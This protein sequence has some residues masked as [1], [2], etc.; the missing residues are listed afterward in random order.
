MRH[1]DV[2]NSTPRPH[3]LAIFYSPASNLP[4]LDRWKE[5]YTL[6]GTILFWYTRVSLSNR[7]GHSQSPRVQGACFH[8]NVHLSIL[9]TAVICDGD[10]RLINGENL[11]ER[12][13]ATNSSH[14]L[15]SAS[16]PNPS[17]IVGHRSRKLWGEPFASRRPKARRSIHLLSNINITPLQLIR[18]GGGASLPI[19][20]SHA[21]SLVPSSSPVL[22]RAAPAHKMLHYSVG[23]STRAACESPSTY[24]PG[25]SSH[26][27]SRRK[28]L[29]YVRTPLVPLQRPRLLVVVVNMQTHPHRLRG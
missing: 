26:H 12:V 11:L 28:A 3:S 6:V 23:E 2:L 27:R 10:P 25:R 8:P 19:P 1:R 4:F 14:L 18:G 15:L 5:G 16:S 29:G 17:S 20:Y 9:L 24:R 7:I 21:H 13:A 22:S